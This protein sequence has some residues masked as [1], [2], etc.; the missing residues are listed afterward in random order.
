M[1][2]GVSGKH[3][4]ID[5]LT[6]SLHFRQQQVGLCVKSLKLDSTMLEA[7][8][9]HCH[10]SYVAELATCIEQMEE[11]A[12]TQ[13][14]L[15]ALE[16]LPP[17][18]KLD[19]ASSFFREASG[20]P[21]FGLRVSI[22]SLWLPFEESYSSGAVVWE[23]T[24]AQHAM[25]RESKELPK[26]LLF[27]HDV[28]QERVKKNLMT[29]G[30]LL[31]FITG[32]AVRSN[33][34]SV[35]FA[36]DFVRTARDLG[37]GDWTSSLSDEGSKT[38]LLFDTEVNKLRQTAKRVEAAGAMIEE[39]KE[40]E[41]EGASFAQ[42]GTAWLR[43]AQRQLLQWERVIYRALEVIISTCGYF[44]E[45][46][47]GIIAED[48]KALGVLR[49][50][51]VKSG[52]SVDGMG[53][54]LLTAT[55]LHS[56]RKAAEKNTAQSLYQI[57][58]L[59]KAAEVEV[60]RKS[61]LKA[62]MSAQ[63]EGRRNSGSSKP[64]GGMM[65]NAAVQD[66]LLMRLKE[67]KV[68]SIGDLPG[69]S[70]KKKKKRKE[71]SPVQ[72]QQDID[73]SALV[74]DKPITPLIAPELPQ[75]TSVLPELM[76]SIRRPGIASTSGMIATTSEERLSPAS[77]SIEEPSSLPSKEGGRS[78]P[79]VDELRRSVDEEMLRVS[80]SDD[81]A[82]QGGGRM[83]PVLDR[84]RSPKGPARQP[85]RRGFNPGMRPMAAN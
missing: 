41:P 26:I 31:N 73:S 15:D 46:D 10:P 29:P 7:S 83:N 69:T 78:S 1:I 9:L 6:P 77:P 34:Q 48:I 30:A 33:N 63:K 20:I 68:E 82:I 57:V 13:E 76:L 75:V 19:E 38:Q 51:G 53:E 8:L 22:L 58:E 49:K 3:V 65:V 24:E 71:K 4:T 43:K 56:V 70:K 44:G 59:Y 39:L 32:P 36:E 16:A 80:H 55:N 35:Q 72:A 47:G 84:A 18:A 27:L 25:Y 81:S 85:P 50:A 5:V 28:A 17:D 79:L 23:R 2:H 66:E 67:V 61:E 11:V 12:P 21:D 37:L 45:I 64:K 40:S 74:A 14:E 60:D 52:G 62:R 42:K 54:R